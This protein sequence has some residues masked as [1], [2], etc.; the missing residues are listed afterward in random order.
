MS[1]Y[2][3]SLIGKSFGQVAA[4][5]PRRDPV[6]APSPYTAGILAVGATGSP[7][8][9][10][11][12]LPPGP[13]ETAPW[14]ESF[15][16]GADSLESSPRGLW[17]AFFH[18]PGGQSGGADDPGGDLRGLAAGEMP[19]ASASPLWQNPAP[20]APDSAAN[21]P[22]RTRRRG[23]PGRREEQDQPQ[24]QPGTIAPRPERGEQAAPETAYW[25]WPST[26][27]V[28]QSPRAMAGQL[29]SPGDAQRDTHRAPASAPK[30]RSAAPASQPTAT[31]LRI[32]DGSR[33]DSQASAQT[34]APGQRESSPGAVEP[35]LKQI[36]RRA[37]TNAGPS[38]QDMQTEQGLLQTG[39]LANTGAIPSRSATIRAAGAAAAG[40]APDQAANPATS[41]ENRG[42]L[43]IQPAL[44]QAPAQRGPG[45]ASR[46]NSD[47][48][49]NASPARPT[50]H[51]TIGRIEVRATPALTAAPRQPATPSAISLDEYLKMRNGGR[52]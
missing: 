34:A 48:T 2:L 5:K 47:L 35:R 11:P 1:D 44:R 38:V 40:T 52:R 19:R 41:P 37:P 9:V 25:S 36:D 50:I 16:P 26:A 30:Q 12:A 21:A 18:G 15:P 10:G 33:V 7:A 23:D 46:A 17:R 13:A 14:A 49:D 28:A 8:A 43:V 29:L 4:L 22:S 24:S 45:M 6:F 32:S 39:P 51:V 3:G 27:S 42:T 20:L 31:S